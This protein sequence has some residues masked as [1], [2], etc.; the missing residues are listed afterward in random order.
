MTFPLAFVLAAA[1]AAA[2]YDTVHLAN[3]GRLRGTV[4]ADTPGEVIVQL[5]DG[6]FRHLARAD[7]SRI[8]YGDEAPAPPAA[9]A[10]A[11]APAPAPPAPAPPV[12]RS[13]VVIPAPESPFS[14][15][16]PRLRR[17]VPGPAA[18][19]ARHPGESTGLQLAVGL[20]GQYAVGRVSKAGP[21]LDDVVEG[22]GALT[23]EAGVKPTPG[24]FIGALV[25]GAAGSQGATF[26]TT[27]ASR[28]NDCVTT[29]GRI[30]ALV[31]FYFAPGASRTP[32]LSLGSGVEQ[33][34]VTAYRRGSTQKV[35]E[36]T[37]TGWE[38]GRAALGIDLRLSEAVGLGFY[39]A[40]SVATF[41]R[42]RGSLAPQAVG[43]R[44]AHGWVGAG[45]RAVIFP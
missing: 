43:G 40:A 32:W 6:S 34:S 25:E 9:A 45:V 26:R 5:P 21:Y 24:F 13:P 3:G 18:P 12:R 20:E 35:A 41:D 10:P 29:S 19:Q 17:A 37:A 31:R 44:S 28:A 30:D 1:L 27:C 2:R 8:D 33:T 11:P 23:L 36:L 22:L 38:I 14:D 15:E 7:V 4:V 42:F 39:A 16:A